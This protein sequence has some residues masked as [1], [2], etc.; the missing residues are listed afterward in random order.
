MNIYT[1]LIR[2]VPG[3]HKRCK[4]N[5][6]PKFMVSRGSWRF[7]QSLKQ[8]QTQLDTGDKERKTF[9]SIP[10]ASFNGGGQL[11]PFVLRE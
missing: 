4:K 6:M 11:E 8:A 9:R 5:V 2:L 3:Q 10:C 7:V 1:K